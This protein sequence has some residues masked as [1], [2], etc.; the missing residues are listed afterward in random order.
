MA[1]DGTLDSAVAA[2]TINVTASNRAP[3]AVDDAISLNEDS[4][5]RFNPLA[6]DSDAEGDRITLRILTNPTHG[7]ITINA[8]Q[9][10]NYTAS[11]DYSGT[12]SFTYE[13]N[14]GQANSQIATVRL[15]VAAVADAP[16]LS[17]DTNTNANT[18]RELFRTGWET[19]DDRNH[20]STLVEKTQLEGWTLMTKP[21]NSRGGSN[22]FEVW[23]TNDRMADNL[24]RQRTVTAMAGNGN[25][26]LELNNARNDMAQSLGIQRQV[27]SVLG[28][29]YTLSMDVAGRLG[30]S[31]DYT[32]IGIYVDG[33][34]IGGDESTSSAT[35]LNWQ[36][37]QF[38]FTGTG[39]KQTIQ[40]IGEATK[41]DG[42]GRGVMIDDIA[43]VERLPANMGLEDT[44]I[45]LSTITARLKDADGSE[46]LALSIEAIPVG[47]VLTDGTRSFTA[48]AN[49]TTATITGWNLANLSLTPPKDFYGKITLQVVA[50]ATERSNGSSN[51]TRQNLVVTVLPVNDA[52]QAQNATYTVASN[53]TVRID[54]GGLVADVDGDALAL[55][56][57][58]PSK[59]M[60][61]KNSD[62]T[63]TYTPKRNASGMD[64]FTYT[65][66]DGITSTTATI[67]LN[68]T[69]ATSGNGSNCGYIVVQSGF[70][71]E[72]KAPDYQYV[73]MNTDDENC[74]SSIN[75]TGCASDIA[76]RLQ[77]PQSI[78]REQERSLTELTGLI[79][80]K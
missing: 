68:I 61:S 52:P 9:T 58:N 11:T 66:S 4:T 76:L 24:N 16:I 25:N 26:W 22:G 65:V 54:F 7:Q 3:V 70:G 37:K 13:L 74:N 48:T 28:A 6:N 67:T 46:T 27:D 77:P 15:T 32:K 62:G 75:W 40:I 64:S 14:D 80:R 21:D 18:S 41:Q 36:S 19:V 1:N 10:V 73:V 57:C 79:V 47:A 20:T 35:V 53:G 12:D 44:A 31:S 39:H 59:G 49:N 17:I 33:V 8:D 38:T 2:V 78:L 71:G 5:I 43:L 30:Y 29:T 69:K 42:N 23:S 56:F 34:R 55:S 60:L 72:H 50:T 51:S 63:W 45:K